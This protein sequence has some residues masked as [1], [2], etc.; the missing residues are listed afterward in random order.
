M[1]DDTTT[2][3]QPSHES[4]TTLPSQPQL[5]A[6]TTANSASPSTTTAASS[7]S[8][9]SS[10]PSR[11]S[12]SP[13]DEGCASSWLSPSSL[14][15]P[16]RSHSHQRFAPAAGQEQ[17]QD[18]QG[19]RSLLML[20]REM[21]RENERL[22]DTIAQLCATQKKTERRLAR[23][24]ED[25]QTIK[26]TQTRM[27]LN[28]KSDYHAI[29]HRLDH[30]HT[31]TSPACPPSLSSSLAAAARPAIP[32]QL[33]SQPSSWCVGMPHVAAAAPTTSRAE[34][35][36]FIAQ[37]LPF[38]RAFDQTSLILRDLQRPFAVMHMKQAETLDD[39]APIIVYAS[40]PLCKLLGYSTFELHGSSMSSFGLADQNFLP[41]FVEMALMPSPT[42][43]GQPLWVPGVLE[44]KGGR[45]MRVYTT[46]Q[47]L[48]SQRRMVDSV[49]EPTPLTTL[50][51]RDIND[52]T[53][54]AIARAYLLAQLPNSL[55]FGRRGRGLGRELTTGLPD[56]AH[57][58]RDS[59]Q[60]LHRQAFVEPVGVVGERTTQKE[61]ALTAALTGQQDEVGA[62][63]PELRADAELEELI[64]V[65]ESPSQS[66][67]GVRSPQM[68]GFTSR[69]PPTPSS[70][71]ERWMR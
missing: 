55:L 43:V 4:G 35:E 70:L 1:S 15:Q 71:A 41:I 20:V 40:P 22:H 59:H 47:F 57:H 46:Q 9:S 29:T 21:R 37:T 36:R 39:L 11:S 28:Q 5:R 2:C 63:Q 18:S 31:H 44:T 12:S 56:A 3:Q 34:V 64:R 48:Y 53:A 6:T 17:E 65:F 16:A 30:V 23:V 14:S 19:L 52:P 66:S 54:R 60:C 10:S 42:P 61:E 58:H 26:L 32:P 45:G 24:E 51:L 33:D 13:A 62:V 49:L 69:P 50:R 67:G 7:T 25:Y 8:P 27:E 68:V 38:L